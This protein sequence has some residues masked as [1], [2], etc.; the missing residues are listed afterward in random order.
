M[1]WT[2][3]YSSVVK[4]HQHHLHPLVTAKKQADSKPT[5]QANYDR[6]IQAGEQQL[7]KEKLKDVLGMPI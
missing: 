1:D 4:W 6:G 3:A 5:K 2:I 7:R